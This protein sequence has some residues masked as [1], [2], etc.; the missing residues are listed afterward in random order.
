LTK[1]L[2]FLINNQP[3]FRQYKGVLLKKTMKSTTYQD[4]GSGFFINIW[5]AIALLKGKPVTQTQVPR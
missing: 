2:G 3:S 1:E 5:V 4:A